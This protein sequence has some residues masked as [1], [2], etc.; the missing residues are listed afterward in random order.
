MVDT[1]ATQQIEHHAQGMPTPCQRKY[2]YATRN[3]LELYSESWISKK[4]IK[5]EA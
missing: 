1:Q 5:I 2:A 3:P 4:S